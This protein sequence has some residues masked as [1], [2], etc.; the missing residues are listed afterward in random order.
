MTINKKIFLSLAV[1]FFATAI[2][3]AGGSQRRRIIDPS[4]PPK[5]YKDG[6]V[7]VKFK[8]G[9]DLAAVKNFASDQSLSLMKRF[10]V[11]T[12]L[13]GQYFTLLKSNTLDAQVL[14]DLL[15]KLPVVEDASPNYR[16]YLD[17]TTPNDPRFSELWGMHNAA[18]HDINAPEAWDIST[19]SS[20]VIVAVID[21]GLDYTH[22][23]LAANAWRNSAEYSGVSGVDDDGNGYVDD[24]YGIDPA[25]DDG[26]GTSGDCDPMDGYG[27][28]THCAGTIGAVGNNSLGV[29]GVNWN[30]KIMGLK[31]FDDNGEN[32]DDAF[33]IECI[34][35]AIDQKTTFGQNIVAINAS[36]GSVGGSDSGTLR[37]AIEAANNAGIVFCA[38]VGN[39]GTDGVGDN[40]DTAG[41]AWHHYPSDYTLPG[42]IAVMATD[43]NDAK[44]S[45]SNYGTTSVDLAAP[46]V[47]ILSTI[48][49]YY[50]PQSGDIFFDSMDVAG[51]WTHGAIQ[52]TDHWAITTNQEGF[53]NTSFPVPSPPNFWSDYPGSNYP[54]NSNT[55]LAYGANINLSGYTGQEIYFG[56]GA[57]WYILASD[58]GYV[59]FSS[60]GG[61]TWTIVF[62]FTN[63]GYYWSNYH[64]LIPESYKTTQFRMRFRLTSNNSNN[65][66]GWLIDNVGI[67]YKN[68]YYEAWDGTS[69]ACPH[70]AG[71]VALMASVFPSET[72]A[73]RKTRILN[74]A[75][76]ISGLSTYCLTSARLNLFNS[77]SYLFVPKSITVTSPNGGESWTVGASQNITW[78]SAGTV[79]VGNVN[80]DYST[81][82]GSNWTSVAGNT[83]NDG[84][85]SWTI[86][87]TPSTTCLV[88]VQETD[89]SPADQSN[90]VFS[91]IAV[92]TVSTPTAP[93]GRAIGTVGTSYTYYTGGSVSSFGHDVQYLFDW[94][95]TSDSGWLAVGTTSASHGWSTAGTYNVRAMCRCASHTAIESAWS[96][97]F[98]VTQDDEPTW[99][100]VSGFEACA[101]ERQ[102][103]VE[104]HTATEAGAVGF[105]LWRQDKETREYQL[106][107]PNFL[108][109]L[110]NSPQGGVYRLADPGAFFGEPVVY[111]LEE[112]DNQG[113]TMMYGPFAVLFGA[114]WNGPDDRSEK[115]GRE[116]TSDIA[117]FQRFGREQ[118]EYERDRLQALRL[119]MQDASVTAS[120]QAKNKERARITVKGRGLF[121]VTSAQVANS[122][123]LAEPAAAVLISGYSLNLTGMGKQIA[124]LADADGAGIFFYN[125]GT[126]TEYSNRNVYWLERGSGRSMQTIHGGNAGPAPEGQTYRETLQ[127]AENH[128]FLPSLKNIT[129]ADNWFWDYIVAGNRS[130]SF[131]VNVPGLAA[132]GKASLRVVF[133]GATDTVVD[134]DHHAVVTLNGSEIGSVSWDG[135]EDHVLEV[136]FS[137]SQLVEG[138]NTI[139]IS[140]TLDSGAPYSIFYVDGFE[141][142]YPRHYKAADNALLCRGDNNPVIT[143]TG[144]TEAKV[145]VLDVS[146]PERPKQVVGV[147]L[148]L[149]GRVTFV[150]R[151]A[152]STYMVSGLNAA[153]RPLA[154]AGDW[155]T[156]LKRLDNAAEYLV[157]APDELA[158][159]AQELADYRQDKGLKSMV[160]TLEDIYDTFNYGMASPLAVRDFL[161][162]AYKKW[163]GKKVKYAVLAGKGTYDY[164]DHLGLGDNLV[165]VILAKSAYG[166]YA[167]DKVFGDVKG[168][169]GVP[170]IAIGRLPAVTNAELRTMIDKIKAYESSGGDWAGKALF[171]ADDMDNG[172]DFA[173][174]SDELAVLATGF[175]AEKIYL[176]GS[177]AEARARIAAAWSSGAGLVNYCGHAGMNQ[178]AQENL[179]DV[180]GARS[181][182]NGNKLPLLVAMTCVAGR[183]EIPGYTSLGEALALSGEG[184]IA[185]GLM[186]SGAALHADSMR[187]GGAFYRAALRGKTLSAGQALVA[188]MKDY[189]NNNGD[190]Y[191]LNVYNWLGDPA[192]EFK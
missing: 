156:R 22:P 15:K 70:V 125:K 124:W 118:S 78:T 3:F 172:G 126:E 88:R 11:L 181:L 85:H 129:L 71:A 131:A 166:F 157:I 16:R 113:R 128:Y 179:L 32:G 37:N 111:R 31:F 89:G 130:R 10:P 107:N 27:H 7:L 108:P 28:G 161:A 91:I 26:S 176:S 173:A 40:N 151:S 175:Q 132:T 79:P 52:G 186:P 47:G 72:V 59:E 46:G 61:S 48:P 64:L 14:A 192:L 105:Y 116:E 8:K 81:D 69:M 82:N 74:Y 68:T 184:G 25:G 115:M 159:A 152:A 94:G 150:P 104:W 119:A 13:K 140:G 76:V 185:G 1:F 167:A 56:F 149:G 92:E 147:A 165:P 96:T 163:V 180:A 20:D 110:P 87:D 95:D 134:N 191:L 183:F 164:K 43:N 66:W 73:A 63:A 57:A 19:G 136:S 171:I 44:G 178:L 9:I 169:N 122:L 62:N 190:K 84:T 2:V 6:E 21:T 67:G 50:T 106:V 144:I 103:T 174:G 51:S 123:G 4:N 121:Y 112:I 114:A 101:S 35:Y 99:V 42:I 158:E 177:A 55:W 97:A 86:P 45:F 83:A 53:L 77:I 120:A 135:G 137:T 17:A 154:V 34:E 41:G 90:A 33:A 100:A 60:D 12:K 143:V 18:N 162:F 189:V 109:S 145:V 23:D 98:A 139:G 5:P 168:K 75:D 148:D 38:A 80:I 170:E 93:T 153:L 142:S 127:F 30:V 133:R 182:Q 138:A 39:G 155:P 58:H 117:G 146:K 54:N 187:L 36:W 102:P 65:A 29:V 160:V 24:I 141:L 188:A 49:P